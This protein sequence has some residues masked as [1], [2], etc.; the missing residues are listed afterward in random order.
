MSEENF[1]ELIR[2][3]R[4]RN[5]EIRTTVLKKL[6]KEKIPLANLNLPDIYKIIY[7]GLNNRD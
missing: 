5:S 1:P 2:R 6:T 3:I 7:D 4:D